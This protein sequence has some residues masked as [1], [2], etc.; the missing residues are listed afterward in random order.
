MHPSLRCSVS[1]LIACLFIASPGPDINLTTDVTAADSGF[2][3]QGNGAARRNAPPKYDCVGDLPYSS[4]AGHEN[5]ERAIDDALD[6]LKN[7]DKCRRMFSKKDPAYAIKLLKRLRRDGVIVISERVP[8]RS[9]LS[10]NGKRLTVYESAKLDDA[11]AV[12]D[13]VSSKSR[14][15][16]KPCI[17]IN[18]KG[19]IVTGERAENYALYPLRRPVQRAVAILH[20]LGHVAGVLGEDGEDTDESRKRSVANTNC[21]R[22][23]CVSCKLYPCPVFPKRPRPSPRKNA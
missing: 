8:V 22:E 21:V 13:L 15:M 16:V 7:C 4:I 1:V 11:A 12:M 9:R 20:E 6:L 17:Y 19:F 18:P 10:R 3:Q 2:A 23:N 14:A 5:V